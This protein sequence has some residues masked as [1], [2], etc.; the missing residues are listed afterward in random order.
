MGASECKRYFVSTDG[1]LFCDVFGER[2]VWILQLEKAT[3]TAE[4]L[5]IERN[6]YFFEKSI[7]KNLTKSKSYNII[8]FAS[9]LAQ[10][11][12]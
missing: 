11:A 2:F 9:D 6:F 12:E 1:V 10:M 8:F 7:N 4:R 5:R 3:H